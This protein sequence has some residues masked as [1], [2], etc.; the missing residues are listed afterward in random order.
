MSVDLSPPPSF[1]SASVGRELVRSI[2]RLKGANGVTGVEC[3][4]FLF[5]F[6]PDPPTLTHAAKAMAR[7]IPAGLFT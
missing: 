7:L 6:S 5:F 1:F 3:Q 4:F 2:L